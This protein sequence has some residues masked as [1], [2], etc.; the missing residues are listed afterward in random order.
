VIPIK[1]QS[2]LLAP[3]VDSAAPEERLSNARFQ[4]RRLCSLVVTGYSSEL[5]DTGTLAPLYY[6]L[7]IGTCV[8]V[9]FRN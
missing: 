9:L 5:S 2:A 8:L 6:R 7:A 1:S 3:C 4:S